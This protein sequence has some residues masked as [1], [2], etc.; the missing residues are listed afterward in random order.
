M[1]HCAID[2][3]VDSCTSCV[4]CARACPTWCITIDAHNESVFDARRPRTV[5]VLD[6][7]TI[8]WGLCMYCGMCIES[9]P[10]DALSWSD[11]R[12]PDAAT[13]TNLVSAWRSDGDR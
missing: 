6:Q 13:R 8:D 5:A 3:D 4:I 1:R 9:C 7:F 12:V 10:F 2:L 11:E